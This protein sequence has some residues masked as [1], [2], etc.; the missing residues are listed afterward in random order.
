[1]H[2][3][4]KCMNEQNAQFPN[5]RWSLVVT[6]RDRPGKESER[7]L[8]AFCQS[9]WSPLYMFARRA[10]LKEPDAK[11]VVQDVFARLLQKGRILQATPS[12]GKMRSFLMTVL[13]NE[14]LERHRKES[15]AK[16]GGK[17]DFESIEME[18]AEERFL[19]TQVSG[20]ELSPEV[21]FDR[22]WARE[23]LHITLR[24][25]KQSY[26]DKG[27]ERL[28]LALEA[29]LLGVDDWSGHARVAASLGMTENAVKVS[30]SRM[31]EK[32]RELFFAE[33]RETL[34][35]VSDYSDEADYLVRC[36]SM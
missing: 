14:I 22:E 36:L 29:A 3:S 23:V 32:V 16:R 15:A 31:R 1:M 34:V 35:D 12:R 18:D 26:V 24:R 25:L 13:Q 20:K 5:T 21:H 10:G 19:K 11:D 4:K 7:A 28:F 8:E 17:I 27:K 2:T 6:I 30:L 9:Y 33:V